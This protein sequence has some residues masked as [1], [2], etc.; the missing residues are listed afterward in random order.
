MTDGIEAM[1][2]AAL[3]LALDASTLRQQAIAANI[4]NANVSGYMP[5]RVDFEQQ[6]GAARQALNQGEPLDRWTLAGV[7]PQLQELG[8]DIASGV[9]PKVMLDMEVAHLA[10]NGVQYQALTTALSR[11]FAILAMAAADGQR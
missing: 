8:N 5:L 7:K 6:L 3:G 2:T 1:T 9:P 11:H 10:Q 4:A